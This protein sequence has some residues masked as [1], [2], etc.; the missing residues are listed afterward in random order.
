M[1]ARDDRLRLL[2]G[3]DDSKPTSLDD[4]PVAAH[5]PDHDPDAHSIRGTWQS[6]RER[7]QAAEFLVATRAQHEAMLRSARVLRERRPHRSA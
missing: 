6:E 3:D 2:L 7:L 4:D 1:S 5:A